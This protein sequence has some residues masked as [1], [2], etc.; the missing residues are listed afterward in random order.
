MSLN[1]SLILLLHFLIIKCRFGSSVESGFL[2]SSLN[3][4]RLESHSPEGDGKGRPGPQASVSCPDCTRFPSRCSHLHLEKGVQST[5]DTHHSFRLRGT[6]GESQVL[7]W[8]LAGSLWR[9]RGA[10]LVFT[11]TQPGEQVDGAGEGETAPC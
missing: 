7:G 5:R 1:Q 2:V 9:P 4:H 8:L 3:W 11:C 6:T 10:A